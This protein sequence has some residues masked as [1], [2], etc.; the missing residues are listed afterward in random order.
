R[1]GRGPRRRRARDAPV[2]RPRGGADQRDRARE[3]PDDRRRRARRRDLRPGRR[4]RLARHRRRG[5]RARGRARRPARRAGR[6]AGR[7]RGRPSGPRP[8]P[9]RPPRR[10]RRPDRRLR[11]RRRPPRHPPPPPQGSTPLRPP[12]PGARPGRA[13]LTQSP[14]AATS[15]VWPA[16]SAWR[17]P[18]RERATTTSR[19]QE[20][21]DTWSGGRSGLRADGGGRWQDGDV[22]YYPARAVV[23]LAAIRANVARLREYAAT[24]QVMAVVKADAYGHGLVPV[25]RAARE[26]GAA[27]LGVAQLSEALALRA[28]GD[29]GRVLAWLYGPGAPLAECV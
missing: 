28:A 20:V 14:A 6:G 18:Q 25:A 4:H 3:G 9:C 24:A 1:R 22:S 23:D 7:A 5:R 10:R 12:H 17:V 15:A 2:G 16:S 19:E 29:T 26:A 13:A 11:R 8:R 21:V 27:W